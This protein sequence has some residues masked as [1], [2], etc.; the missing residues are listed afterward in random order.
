MNLM[1]TTITCPHCDVD[2]QTSI[3]YLFIIYDCQQCGG[4]FKIEDNKAVKVE[5]KTTMEKTNLELAQ[6]AKQTTMAKINLELA[7]AAIRNANAKESYDW[8]SQA[9][10]VHLDAVEVAIEAGMSPDDIYRLVHRDTFRHEIAHR[11]RL[12]ARYMLARGE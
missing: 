12:A 5:S 3:L 6:E 11:C 7:Q 8:L 1:L 10:P 9:S 4:K 2:I